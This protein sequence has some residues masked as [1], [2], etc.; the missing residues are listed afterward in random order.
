MMDNAD[1]SRQLRKQEKRR[2]LLT[3]LFAIAA[4]GFLVLTFWQQATGTLPHLDIPNPQMPWRNA[5]DA[6][7]AA[8]NAILDSKKVDYAG[9]TRHSGTGDDVP[10][11]WADKAHLVAEN[12]PA[13]QTLQA[14]FGNPY[15]APP[16]RS[17]SA[18][19]PYYASFRK[20]ARLL[21]LK[22]Q[23]ELQRGDWYAAANTGM[24]AMFMGTQMTHGAVLIGSLVGIA[25][26]AIG[27]RHTWETVDHLTAAQARKATARMETILNAPVS[28]ADT[29]QE[30][31]W[32]GQA[33]MIEAFRKSGGKMGLQ[34]LMGGGAS[35]D[36]QGQ[37]GARAGQLMLALRLK[38]IGPRGVILNYT[39]YM[40]SLRAR[41]QPRYAERGPT[42]PIPDDPI[43]QILCPVFSQADFKDAQTRVDNA[44]LL[45]SFA[46]RAY[47]LEH[48]N[49]PQT[50]AE[51]Q[52]GGYLKRIPQD[53]FGPTGSLMYRLTGT[54]YLLYSVGPDGK[55]DGG[56]PVDDPSRANEPGGGYSRHTVQMDST[57]DIVAGVNQ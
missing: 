31:E 43:N 12:A 35:G 34:D 29:L 53:P 46:L 7:V 27:R 30:E 3:A 38:M 28:F 32:M 40:D 45:V 16:A 15:V 47:Y 33:G 57:G 48:R 8:S 23:V 44:L 19:F 4:L 42:P 17:F 25:C 6:Y 50:L 56:K 55:D 51:L 24:D 22:Q 41:A 18:L 9:S 49:Y 54:Q 21:A 26:Q 10:Y 37:V 13:I 36:N 1:R 52:Q 20:M 2:N 11:T 14:S 39:R 5:H